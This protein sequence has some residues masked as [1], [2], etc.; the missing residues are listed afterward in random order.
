MAIRPYRISI[1]FLQDA[2]YLKTLSCYQTEKFF[3]IFL[4]TNSNRM[5]VIS[6]NGCAL[7]NLMLFAMHI[8]VFNKF[9][10]YL[11]EVTKRDM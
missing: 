5:L 8:C 4:K 9:V 11:K 7:D 6:E 10:Q 2:Y 1:F 3:S